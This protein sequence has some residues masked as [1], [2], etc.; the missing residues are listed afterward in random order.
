MTARRPC[1]VDTNVIVV[2]N[3]RG[4]ES[5][6][7]AYFCAQALV[8]IRE[9]GLLILDD[10]GRIIGEY[11]SNC[12]PFGEPG[13]GNFFTKW[14]HDHQGRNEFVQTI[15]IT[16]RA[17]DPSDFTEFPKH[18]GL[19]NFDRSDRKFVAVANAH[20]EKPPILE[21]SDTKW[22]GWKDALKACGI[23]IVFLCPEEIEQAYNR[24]F[25]EPS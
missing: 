9:S 1:V 14:I 23:T 2:A 20:R 3:Q 12:P 5:R 17:D 6:S 24:K 7:C 4:D 21:A 18:D 8:T 10:N 11:F 15:A 22:W 19:S 13:V 16:P 25:G